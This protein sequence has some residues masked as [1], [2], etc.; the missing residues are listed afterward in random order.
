MVAIFAKNG[1]AEGKAWNYFAI[2]LG[3][4]CLIA[5]LITF[6][7]TKGRDAVPETAAETTEKRT[8]PIKDYWE[9]IKLKPFK[10]IIIICV[11]FGIGYMAFQSGL[12]YYILFFAGMTEAQMSSAMFIN[13]F[14]SMAITVVISILA[15]K[16][17]KNMAVAVCLCFSALG[18][19]IL[20]IAGVKSFGMLLVL[21]AVFG[22]GN[23]SFWLLIYPIVYDI[24]EVYEYKYGKRK[25][26]TILSVYAFVFTLATSLGTQV[27]T[28]LLTI[29]GYDPTLPQQSA[30][31]V[32]GIANI[33]FGVPIATFILGGIVCIIYPMTKKTYTKLMEQLDSKRNGRET[34]DS[35]LG[36]IV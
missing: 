13:I 1:V 21:L 34:D 25:E 12:I 19:I 24:S 15:G 30:E 3:A 22:F 23:A 18:M 28:T 6:F 4:A 9:I 8:N 32:S 10:W 11:L 31:T 2:I 17:H 16:I 26:G 36:R 27:L 7:T 29:A 35:E 33:V 20:Y 14:V 5:I